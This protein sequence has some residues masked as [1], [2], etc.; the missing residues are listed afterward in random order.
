MLL[1]PYNIVFASST[2]ERFGKIEAKFSIIQRSKVCVLHLFMIKYKVNALEPISSTCPKRYS[3]P[4]YYQ[5]KYLLKKPYANVMVCGWDEF[6]GG[7]LYLGPY[8][9]RLRK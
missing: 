5:N 6:D 3:C 9:Y 1:M 8:K 7:H 4:K 2:G